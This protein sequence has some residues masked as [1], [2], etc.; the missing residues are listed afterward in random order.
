VRAP[1]EAS[2]LRATIRR[3]EF[4]LDGPLTFGYCFF[5]GDCGIFRMHRYYFHVK[6]GQMTELDHVGVELADIAEATW[7]AARRAQEIVSR[8]NLNAI[9]PINGAIVIADDAWQ[10]VSEMPF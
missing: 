3:D 9:P 6:R 5:V 7:E 10:T 4:A 1:A 2:R 8:N